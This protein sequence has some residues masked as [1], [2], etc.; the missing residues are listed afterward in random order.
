[1]DS[2]ACHRIAVWAKC[3]AACGQAA[4]RTGAR[5]TRPWSS[6]MRP[7]AQQKP[8]LNN[9]SC[10]SLAVF[11][12]TLCDEKVKASV[13]WPKSVCQAHA[14]HIPHA[15][16]DPS[17][18]DGSAW[19]PAIMPLLLRG[20]SPVPWPCTAEPCWPRR[21]NARQSLRRSGRRADYKETLPALWLTSHRVLC[22]SP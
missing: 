7:L 16:K 13:A 14:Q 10:F 22:Q 12:I 9:A 6:G 21:P 19:H 17:H 3:S 2:I 15:L 1:M 8:D 4:I 5:I 18:D 11:L 20:N